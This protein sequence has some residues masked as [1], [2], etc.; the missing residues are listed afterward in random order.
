MLVGM[1]SNHLI[2]G[3]IVSSSM[4][5]IWSSTMVFFFSR[6]GIFSLLIPSA[7]LLA[8]SISAPKAL[9]GLIDVRVRD[10]QYLTGWFDSTNHLF[11]CGA[12]QF[13]QLTAF[14]YHQ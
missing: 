8:I 11:G 7:A 2:F 4:L 9:I 6:S 13:W 14:F 1:S 3:V 12:L 10:V 5:F